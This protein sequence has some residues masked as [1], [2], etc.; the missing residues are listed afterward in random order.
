MDVRLQNAYVQVVLDNFLEVVKQ[1]LLFQAQLEVNKSFLS[2]AE[3]VK[4]K[5]QELSERNLEL[6][7]NLESVGDVNQMAANLND[8][9]AKNTVLQKS[10]NEKEI[11]LSSLAIELSTTKSTLN[12][13]ETQISS[14]VN[15]IQEKERLQSAVN[16]YMRQLK[17]SKD[18]L[19]KVKSESQDVLMQNNVRI[20]ELTKYVTRLEAVVP[21]SKLKRVKLGEVIQPDTP[22]S[23]ESQLPIEDN[24]K[25]GGTF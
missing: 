25:A 4:R 19:L 15:A 2:E 14:Q 23:T 10:L 12:Q 17:Q 8:A 5:I 24:V 3:E 22:E 11:L 1:N 7:K 16:D 13:K 18:E 9:I 20:E 6:Q 21:A